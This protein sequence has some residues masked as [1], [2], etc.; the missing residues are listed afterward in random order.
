M[1]IDCVVRCAFQARR[2]GSTKKKRNDSIWDRVGSRLV[3]GKE[4]ERSL[5]EGGAVEQRL[6]EGSRPC[7]CICEGCIMAVV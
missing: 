2:Y 3:V 7:C 4:D 1:G 5:H 6:K